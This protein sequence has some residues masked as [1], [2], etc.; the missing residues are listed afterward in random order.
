MV[1]P[2]ALGA[3]RELTAWVAL[4][5]ALVTGLGAAL[6]PP[7]LPSATRLLR[8]TAGIVCALAGGAGLAGSLATR[9]STLVALS[10]LL[11]GAA[12]VVGLSHMRTIRR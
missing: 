3:P 12:V 1:S 9:T 8:G 11:L 5:V 6:S 2:A 7:T 10:V 4:A